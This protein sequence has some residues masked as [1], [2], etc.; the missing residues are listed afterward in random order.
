MIHP[1]PRH[2][3]GGLGFRF[4]SP[5][6]PMANLRTLHLQLLQEGLS[7]LACELTQL[8]THAPAPQPCWRP[9]LNVYRCPDRFV[10]C[11]ELAG[12]ERSDIALQVEA[13][14]VLLS[15]RRDTP[16]RE[17]AHGAL[18]QVLAL[19]ID[20]G[21]CAREVVLPEAIVPEGVRAEQRNGLLWIELPL[22]AAS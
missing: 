11:V 7:A 2:R 4:S 1:G 14:R 8:R 16:V 13:N 15:G 5:P 21:R 20:D 17:E 18:L 22:R 9:R 3:P 6:H 12:M 10:I 19:E